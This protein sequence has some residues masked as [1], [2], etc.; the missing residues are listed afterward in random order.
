[1]P[2]CRN[3]RT[4]CQP[5][6]RPIEQGRRGQ[7]GN[8]LDLIKPSVKVQ[9]QVPCPGALSSWRV[10]LVMLRA[11]PAWFP[12]LLPERED[13][14]A[15]S[16]PSFG[17]LRTRCRTLNISTEYSKYGVL[18]ITCSSLPSCPRSAASK[19]FKASC[20]SQATPACMRLCLSAAAVTRA[21]S[22]VTLASREKEA[23]T[24]GQAS[25]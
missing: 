23:S 22:S 25:S 18:S 6:R 1:M 24:T 16:P 14:A 5:S 19:G 9:V 21:R 17:N 13:R 3:G 12:F 10:R 8:I 15:I 2:V 20:S 11:V 4:F 7:Q